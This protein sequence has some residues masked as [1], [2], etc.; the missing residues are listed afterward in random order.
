M[1]GQPVPIK[2]LA[3]WKCWWTGSSL[4][5]EIAAAIQKNIDVSKLP[6]G[7]KLVK[8][9]YGNKVVQADLQNS[10]NNKVMEAVVDSYPTDRDP[11][12]YLLG[13]AVLHL[14]SSLQGVIFGL[15]KPNPVD[16][17]ARRKV[18]LK[19]GAY[20]KMML[21]YL[22]T[23]AGRANSGRCPQVTY[24]KELA[25]A[26]GLRGGGGRGKGSPDASPAPSS[27]SSCSSRLSTATTILDGNPLIPMDTAS[28]SSGSVVTTPA[29]LVSY[30]AKLFRLMFGKMFLFMLRLT[31]IVSS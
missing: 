9:Q 13:D 1:S 25:L 10:F 12:A 26:K 16:E 19:Q 31:M 7:G 30:W 8:L 11:S 14:N 28:K 22:R 29:N 23:I 18:A 5:G 2:S 27:A 20:L 4:A 6:G 21:S 3:K 15:Q 24:L 17:D